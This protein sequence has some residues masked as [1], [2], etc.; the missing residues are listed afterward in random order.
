MVLSVLL[1]VQCVLR[2]ILNG[3]YTQNDI[4]VFVLEI[5]FHLFFALS[6]IMLFFRIYHIS[7]IVNDR[8]LLR[9]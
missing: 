5:C 8:V 9:F 4:R 6:L 2:L 1:Q 7:K 3:K